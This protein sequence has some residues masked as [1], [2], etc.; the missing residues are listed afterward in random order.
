MATEPPSVSTDPKQGK[1][2]NGYFKTYS[3]LAPALPSD[4]TCSYR[5]TSTSRTSRIHVSPGLEYIISQ[6][7]SSQTPNKARQ[8]RVERRVQPSPCKDDWSQENKDKET[9][10]LSLNMLGN[11]E[12]L[13]RSKVKRE[14][15]LLSRSSL[16]RPHQPASASLTQTQTG[17]CSLSESTSPPPFYPLARKIDTTSFRNFALYIPQIPP[18]HISLSTLSG[19][20]HTGG[21]VTSTPSND[22]NIY[23][24]DVIVDSMSGCILHDPS[25]ISLL[26]CDSAQTNGDCLSSSTD[27]VAH[28]EDLRGGTE[29]GSSNWHESGSTV[30][31]QTLPPVDT[32]SPSLS[33]RSHYHLPTSGR[34]NLRSS[35]SYGQEAT[36]STSA[37]PGREHT[38][39]IEKSSF[40][41]HS[42]PPSQTSSFTTASELSTQDY[43]LLLRLPRFNRVL[44]LQRAPY[45]AHQVSF[46]D[47]GAT[48]GHPVFVFL[49]LGGIRY[50]TVLFEDLA[51]MMNLRLICVD[52]WGLGKTD[53]VSAERRGFIEWAKVIEEV[54][55]ELGIDKFGILAHSAGSPYAMAVAATF[56]DRLVGSVNLLAPWVGLDIEGGYKWLKYVPTTIIK[57]TQAAEWKMQGWMLGK[58]SN[59][60]PT[61]SSPRSATESPVSIHSKIIEGCVR[62]SQESYISTESSRLSQSQPIA[63]LS[64]SSSPSNEEQQPSSGDTSLGTALLRACHAENGGRTEDLLAIM[65]KPAL[66]GFSY[67]DV[68][69]QVNV[70]YGDRDDRISEKS[71]LWMERSLPN[72]QLFLRPGESHDLLSSTHIVLEVLERL[73]EDAIVP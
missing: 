64:R 48:T 61:T 49:G 30:R 44:T 50:L 73:A 43:A 19:A 6:G 52:R 55:D 56:P 60:S 57:A 53:E 14:P 40:S 28:L 33:K 18:Y 5:C 67:M 4:P 9:Q 15:P 10:S 32:R 72:C 46:S 70:W 39:P 7:A 51:S 38:P 69:S 35:I 2:I 36:S 59:S 17:R 26:T 24:T 41:G 8:S 3:R 66:W 71:I 11:T 16:E 47:I 62:N 23:D 1:T 25:S 31:K 58:A 54:T 29:K 12:T 63:S 45:E 20:L 68:Q 37:F 13:C 65:R 27:S 22:V 21:Q 34:S 42:T